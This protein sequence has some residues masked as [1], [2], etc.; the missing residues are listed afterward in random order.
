MWILV[1]ILK[2]IGIILGGIIGLLLL[3]L[4]LVMC[5]PIRYRIQGSNRQGTT[6]SFC[7][8]WLLSIVVVKK[9]VNS[10]K[11]VLS[12]F[13][14]PIKR[15][16]GSDKKKNDKESKKKTEHQQMKKSSSSIKQV[17]SGEQTK[18]QH[19]KKEQ[20]KMKKNFSFDKL[21][22][23]IGLVKD[24]NNR[25]VAKR[26]FREFKQLVK[27]LSPTKIR[28]EMI[29][30]T[31]DPCTTGFVFGGISLIPLAYEDGVHIMPDFAEKRFEADGYMKGKIRVIY[32]LRFV[33]RLYKDRELKRLWK[34]INKVKKEAA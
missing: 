33:L 27:Y 25:N 14:I 2:W 30:G 5:V 3:L 26:L 16:A 12:V 19:T 31:G 8:R 23:I 28:G 6:Y 15:L 10:Q 18:Q 11:I 17:P 1:A 22:S 4:A 20:R 32:F 21:S 7:F 13:G 34:Q 29:V 24:N 9:K